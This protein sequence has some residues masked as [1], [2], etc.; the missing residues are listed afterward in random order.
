LTNP[1]PSASGHDG[2]QQ[3][4]VDALEE[5][6][7]LIAG[8]RDDDYGSPT[9]NFATIADFLT[10]RFSDKLVPGETFTAAE[11]ADIMILVKIARNVKRPSRDN[12]VDIAGYAGCGYEASL[13]EE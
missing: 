4:R 11:V 2:L 12:W 10:T 9:K 5:A 13:K 3:P 6:A 7:R 1:T 8:A